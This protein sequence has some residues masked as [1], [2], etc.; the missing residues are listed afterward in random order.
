MFNELCKLIV[1]ISFV[2]CTCSSLCALLFCIL[3]VYLCISVILLSTD[4][5]NLAFVLQD[6]NKRIHSFMSKP[7]QSSNSE[8][9]ALPQMFLLLSSIR[10]NTEICDTFTA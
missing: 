5:F 10:K 4:C 6:F 1:R 7:S 9:R 8:F 2:Y 3:A